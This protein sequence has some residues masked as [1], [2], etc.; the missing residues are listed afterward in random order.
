[1]TPSRFIDLRSGTR[2]F[3]P[4]NTV[5]AFVFWK[6]GQA[7]VSVKTITSTHTFLFSSKEDAVN[8]VECC[9]K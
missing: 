9:K 3:V 1:M 8:F 4:K 5:D 2:V 6:N 7:E